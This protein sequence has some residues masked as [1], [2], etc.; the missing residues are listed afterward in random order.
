MNK[1]SFEAELAEKG[2]I[3][4]PNVGVSMRPLIKQGRDVMVIEKPTGRLKR[5]D[6]A[7]Y[8][9]KDGSYVMHRVLKVRENDYV[10]CGDNCIRKEY[11]ITDDQIIGVLTAVL[12]NG[13]EIKSTDLGYRIYVHI[14][15]DLFYLRIAV[16][17][18]IR[19]VRAVFRRIGRLFGI[20]RNK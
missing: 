1:S 9:R 3:I 13:K 20:K 14:W 18:G 15:C 6:G 11:G 12:R 5:Y 19:I 8:V 2:R 7:L 17:W 4:Y 16:L 10:I